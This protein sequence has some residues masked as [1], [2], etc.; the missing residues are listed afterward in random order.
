MKRKFSMLLI[1]VLITFQVI[2]QSPVFSL[3]HLAPNVNHTGKVWL[4]HLSRADSTFDYNI[5]VAKFDTGAKLNWH[6]HPKGQQLLILDGIGYYQEKSQPV[7]IVTKGDVIKCQPETEHWHGATPN[8]RVTYVAISGN[9]RTEWLDKVTHEYFEEINYDS[10][11]RNSLIGEIEELSK[12]KWKLMADKNVEEL[13]KIFHEKAQFVHMGGSWGKSR[14][15]EIIKD[16]SIHYKQTEIHSVTVNLMDN[17]AILLNE[18]TL[19]AVVGDK[20]VTNRFMVT[21]VYNQENEEWKLGSLS[22]TKLLDK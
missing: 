20:E 16:G 3:G 18:I 13:N 7:Q 17:A 4:N 21:E 1:G 15:L 6:R 8:H 11:Q 22:F 12:L 14:E 10:I 5:A 9:Q 2:A 19:Q